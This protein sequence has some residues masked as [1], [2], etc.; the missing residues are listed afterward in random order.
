MHCLLVELVSNARRIFGLFYLLF[1]IVEFNQHDFWDIW[2]FSFRYPWQSMLFYGNE[3]IIK[4]RSISKNTFKHKYNY[5][6][7]TIFWMKR[8]ACI[9][10]C[11]GCFSNII[12]CKR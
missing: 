1:R 8:L 7:F 2:N 5:H 10:F 11:S 3:V 9:F 6:I 4:A 12:F